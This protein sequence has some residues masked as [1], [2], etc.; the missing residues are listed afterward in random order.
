MELSI[1]INTRD[2]KD[3]LYALLENVKQCVLP[4]SYE[5]IVVED[6]SPDD[7]SREMKMKFPKVRFIRNTKRLFLIESRTLVGKTQRE[8]SSFL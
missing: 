4:F 7:Y 1:I 8:L 2:R 6:A 5:V 3:M